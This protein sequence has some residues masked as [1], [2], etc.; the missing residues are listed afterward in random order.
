V[1]IQ[2]VKPPCNDSTLSCRL[3]RVAESA[4]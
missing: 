3:E 1:A 4:D 2:P